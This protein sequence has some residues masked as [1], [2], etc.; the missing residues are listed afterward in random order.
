MGTPVLVLVGCQEDPSVSGSAATYE[1]SCRDLESLQS[2]GI[3]NFYKS[4]HLE[5]DLQLRGDKAAASDAPGSNE[6]SQV[7]SVSVPPRNGKDKLCSNR[8]R[9]EQFPD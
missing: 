5:E 1:L 4:H 3:G 6:L 7:L 8:E 2:S 9:E